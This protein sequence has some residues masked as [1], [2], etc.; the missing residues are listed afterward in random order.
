MDVSDHWTRNCLSKEVLKCLSH[1]PHIPSVLVLNKV[2]EELVFFCLLQYV[3][4]V[5][6]DSTWHQQGCVFRSL[7]LKVLKTPVSPSTPEYLS[8]YVWIHVICSHISEAI[9]YRL[10]FKSAWKEELV[11]QWG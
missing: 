2:N 5:S 10:G 3:T 11:P 4:P 9:C 7:S 6:L 8:V 1:F